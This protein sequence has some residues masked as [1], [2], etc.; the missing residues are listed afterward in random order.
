MFDYLVDKVQRRT[1]AGN[2]VPDQVIVTALVYASAADARSIGT[3][4][5]AQGRYRLAE[6]AYRQAYNAD[7]TEHGLTHPD[8]LTSRNNLALVLQGLGRLDE[9]E[10]EHRAV[11]E[12][13]RRTLGDEHPHTLTSRNNLASVLR[14]LG[15]PDEAEEI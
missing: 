13:R 11:L 5:Y 14:E 6:R 4:A 15:R 3:T 1:P 12:A 7:L 2:H 8:T 10:T 9:A